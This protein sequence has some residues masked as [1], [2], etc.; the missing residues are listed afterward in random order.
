MQHPEMHYILRPGCAFWARSYQPYHHRVHY[1]VTPPCFGLDAR[2]LDLCLLS[3]F[4]DVIH[5]RVYFNAS[6]KQRYSALSHGITVAYNTV[7][8][9]SF[10]GHIFVHI[11][12][13]V[14]VVQVQQNDRQWK[15]SGNTLLPR[16]TSSAWCTVLCMI[17]MVLMVLCPG[18]CDVEQTDDKL[19]P[20]FL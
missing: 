4:V 19:G 7:F 3:N 14:T 1:H 10:G 8:I 12:V 20:E 6:F 9:C 5:A 2:M 17:F 18:G 15:H 16:C 11:S 13:G